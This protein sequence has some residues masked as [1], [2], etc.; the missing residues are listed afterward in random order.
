VSQF[1]QTQRNGCGEMVL[2]PLDQRVHSCPHCGL[3]MDRDL[4]AAINILRRGLSSLAKSG[5]AA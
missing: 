1:T 2:K 5:E 4:N 3:E